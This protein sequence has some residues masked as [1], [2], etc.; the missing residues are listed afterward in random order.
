MSSSSRRGTRSAIAASAESLSPAVRVS[1]P[2]SDRIP[3]TSSRISVSSSTTRISDAILDLFRPFFFL[4]LACY[5]HTKNHADHRS[6]TPM[7]VSRSV[8]QLQPSTMVL[9]YLLHDRKTKAGALLARGHI[10]LQKPLTVLLRQ[11]LAGIHHDNFNRISEFLRDDL[12][13][14]LSRHFIR[15]I[16]CFRRIL[17]DVSESLAQEARIKTAGERLVAQHPHQPD[18]RTT[19]LDQER[20][21]AQWLADIEQLHVGFRHTRE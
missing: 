16:N 17:D 19:D 11:P 9:D 4:T 5:V 8:V 1:W 12:D 13:N 21:F 15:R 6:A 2:S 20:G 7:E 10:R 14:R 3:A 18:I